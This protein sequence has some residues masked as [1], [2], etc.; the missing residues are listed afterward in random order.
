MQYLVIWLRQ[1]DENLIKVDMS[2]SWN[3]W[4]NI[5][6]VATNMTMDPSAKERAPAKIRGSMFQGTSND[7]RLWMYGG[8]T[9]YW[10]TS[11]PGW[12]APDG[13]DYALWSY[14]TATGNWTAHN[15]S[16][17]SPIPP[18]SGA[19]AEA[20]DQGLA[21]YFNGEIDSGSAVTTEDLTDE[22]KIFQQGM[23]VLDTH[24]GTATNL[25]TSLVVGDLP[26]TRGILE[27][28]PGIGTNGILIAL[29]GSYKRTDELDSNE[30][31]SLVPM[32]EISV[33]DISSYHRNASNPQW[34]KQNAT[35]S[36]P[37]PRVEF[38][39]VMISA[40]DNSS[41]NIHIYGGRGST[42]ETF[43]DVWVLSLPSFT[44]TQ[45]YGAGVSPRFGHTCH[46][47]GNRT[48]LTVGGIVSIGS[49]YIGACDWEI[50]GV[51]VFDL[52]ALVW[53]TV[54]LTETPEYEVPSLLAKTIGG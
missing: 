1:T 12:R 4:T 43:D 27:Y 50:K 31:E 32:T 28:V 53:G 20:P 21:F 45:I 7:T 18:S 14:D 2:V 51:A 40:P 54:Y 33:F 10:N 41:H 8:T 47:M 44:W 25:S 23:I 26:R 5:S 48:L 34:Y 9:S 37:Q 22:V 46:L 36:I 13:P 30:I 19:F 17:A 24:N 29:G 11:F 3:W 38:C 49:P 16:S 39:S 35:G 52:T 15:V 6:E 42:N